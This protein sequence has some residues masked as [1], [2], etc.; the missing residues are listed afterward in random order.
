MLE[1][2]PG[3]VMFIFQPAEEGVPTGERGGARMMVEDG[4]FAEPKPDAVIAFHTNGVPPDA[5]RDDERLG[6][7]AYSVRPRPS[8][9]PL[10]RW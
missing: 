3:T 7:V 9:P 8:P 6:S 4:I 5:E 10:S 1:R 2:L